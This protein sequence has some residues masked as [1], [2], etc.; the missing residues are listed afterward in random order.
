LKKAIFSDKAV[1]AEIDFSKH[2]DSVNVLVTKY[3]LHSQKTELHGKLNL[4]WLP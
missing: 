4:G 1:T 3:L 2:F